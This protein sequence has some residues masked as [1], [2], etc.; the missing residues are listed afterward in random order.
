M[1]QEAPYPQILADLVERLKYRDGWAFTLEDTDRGQGSKGLTLTISIACPDSYGRKAPE[2]TGG[3]THYMLV[4]PAAYDERSWTDWLFEQVGLVEQHERMEFFKVD[5]KPAYPPA[6]G[7]G[8]SPYLR[9][10]YGTD[11]DR[12]T[13]FRGELN[14]E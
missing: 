6:H 14:P 8:N 12:R 13:S 7:P 3:V 5:G 9:M 1:R 10:I 11:I 4:P 2:W